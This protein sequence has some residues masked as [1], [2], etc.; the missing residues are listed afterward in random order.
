MVCV[1]LFAQCVCKEKQKRHSALTVAFARA[2]E[3][4]GSVAS[5]QL[6]DFEKG[7]D[8]MNLM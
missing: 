1:C 7:F 5:H 2:C 4:H 3:A 8:A 6:T